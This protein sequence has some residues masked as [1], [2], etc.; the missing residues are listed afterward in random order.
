VRAAPDPHYG[1]AVV[2]CPSCGRA[3]VRRAHAGMGN[4]RATR[5]LVR[6]VLG[7]AWRGA[8]V[9]STALLAAV[10][11]AYVATGLDRYQIL[12]AD[13]AAGLAGLDRR[14]R[15]GLGVWFDSGGAY[16]LAGV[17][18]AATIAGSALV[19]LLDH[20]RPHVLALA[21]AGAVGMALVGGPAIAGLGEWAFDDRMTLQRAAERFAPTRLTAIHASIGVAAAL[22]V[23]ICATPIGASI[24]RG[25]AGR[26]ARR[27]RRRREKLRRIARASA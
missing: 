13:L 15:H 24:R 6:S 7:L 8:A 21:W 26:A 22:A 10:C 4:V 1:L 14:A 16:A 12:P 20:W 5:H 2:V 27:F 9:G 3:C 17:V 25:T 18:I 23:T 19:A 11:I